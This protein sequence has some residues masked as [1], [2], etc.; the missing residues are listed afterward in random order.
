MCPAHNGRVISGIGL[1][2]QVATVPSW[3]SECAKPKSRGCW[4]M[5]EGGLQTPAWHAASSLAIAS[6]SSKAKHNGEVQ[7]TFSFFPQRSCLSLSTSF[8]SPQVGLLSTACLKKV[9]KI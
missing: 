1:E 7:W 6:S 9:H 2:L 3:Q 8:L 5:I 4:V